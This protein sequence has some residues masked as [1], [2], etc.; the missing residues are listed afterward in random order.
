MYT[1][2]VKDHLKNGGSF[3]KMINS[4]YNNGGSETNL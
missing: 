3:W 1:L 2:E 4:Y